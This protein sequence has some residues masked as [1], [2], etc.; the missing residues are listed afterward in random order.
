M[1]VKPRPHFCSP[2]LI[3]TG[4][5][6]NGASSGVLKSTDGGDT[7]AIKSNGLW[8]TKIRSIGCASDDCQHVYVGAGSSIYETFDG[9]DTW[10]LVNASSKTGG[11]YQFKNGT[12]AGKKYIFASCD[13]GIAN[14]PAGNEPGGEWNVVGPGGWGRGGYLSLS[15]GVPGTSVLGGC[16]GGHV[17]VGTVVNTTHTDWNQTN[18]SRPVTS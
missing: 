13:G 10:T 2:K 6:N 3:Y 4:G 17:F 15:E 5:Q 1:R 8:D 12:I 18:A 9:A 7:W 14:V 16:L 11:C